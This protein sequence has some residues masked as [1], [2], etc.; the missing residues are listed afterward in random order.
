[1]FS[2]QRESN[3]NIFGLTVA[4][5]PE[6][7]ARICA[8]AIKVCLAAAAI[9]LALTS[10]MVLNALWCLGGPSIFLPNADCAFL[11]WSSVA[12]CVTALGTAMTAYSTTTVPRPWFA[13]VLGR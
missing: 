10:G 11:L 3:I 12:G 13:T 4:T 5:G 7:R 2:I 6:T 8:L 1:M 9:S